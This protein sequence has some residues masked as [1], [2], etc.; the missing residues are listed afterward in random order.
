MR[1]GV[2]V[3][4]KE[5]LAVVLSD[6]T[7]QLT[8]SIPKIVKAAAKGGFGYSNQSK[9]FLSPVVRTRH[10]GSAWHLSSQSSLK[11]PETAF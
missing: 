4:H 8:F 7:S 10:G 3:D 9:D 1:T 2:Q 6:V 11:A 5:V